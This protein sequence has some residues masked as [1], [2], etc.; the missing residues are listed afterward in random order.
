M[1]IVAIRSCGVSAR[2]QSSLVLVLWSVLVGGCATDPSTPDRIETTASPSVHVSTKPS[3][4]GFA[5]A[6]QHTTSERLA[7]M[8]VVFGPEEA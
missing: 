1:N 8:T 4:D 7:A 2:E 6:A 5:G 3:P